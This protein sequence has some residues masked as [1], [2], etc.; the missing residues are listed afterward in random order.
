MQQLPLTRGMATARFTSTEEEQFEDAGGDKSQDMKDWPD[1]ENPK[2]QA[3]ME[4]EGETS[5]SEGKTGDQPT[6]AKGGAPAPPKL[7]LPASTPSD[8]KPG[9]SKDRMQAPTKNPEE[10]TPPNLTEYIKSYQQ[11]GKDW[12]DSVLENK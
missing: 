8:P 2:Q 1:V 10:E 5:K 6:E 4:G 11:A 3:A 7:N 12:L 9:T